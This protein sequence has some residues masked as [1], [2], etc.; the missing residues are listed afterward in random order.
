MQFK[1]S[2][3]SGRH[4]R[5]IALLKS[6]IRRRRKLGAIVISGTEA[7]KRAQGGKRQRALKEVADELGLGLIMGNGGSNDDCWVMWDPEV[8]SLVWGRSLPIDSIGRPEKPD[9]IF[10]VLQSK[11]SDERVLISVFHLPHGVEIKGRFLPGPMS[12]RWKEERQNWVDLV[13]AKAA[14]YGADAKLMGGDWNF[15]LRQVRFQK[16]L[17]KSMLN[18]RFP[19]PIPNKGSHKKSSR[20]I[21]F[22]VI[23]GGAIW[24][25]DVLPLGPASD[26]RE[27]V[28]TIVVTKKN[29][30]AKGSAS[31]PVQA[32]PN[33]DA[34]ISYAKRKG[35]TAR[36]KHLLAAKNLRK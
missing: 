7:D 24:S 9:A 11:I 6:S 29:T 33:L 14:Q 23:S 12:K 34:A 20:L 21:D 36:L 8:F 26:H 28:Q 10:A 22:F 3:L 19:T 18:W 32:D 25:M 13:N 30:T 35:W 5:S 31:K 2:H 15:N 16:W 1:H 27:I 4:D 17:R